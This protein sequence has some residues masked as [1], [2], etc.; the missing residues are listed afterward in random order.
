[1]GEI[2]DEVMKHLE[3]FQEGCK[4]SPALLLVALKLCTKAV[5]GACTLEE[6]ALIPI[7]YNKF[8]DLIEVQIKQ[9]LK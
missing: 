5:E 6:K 1:M 8:E 9:D 7:I 3:Y 4:G 2:E